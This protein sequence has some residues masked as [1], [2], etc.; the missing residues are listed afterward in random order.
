MLDS[1]FL[2]VEDGEE[3]GF[4][5]LANADDNAIGLGQ[6]RNRGKLLFARTI[7][8]D[9]L[10][11]HAGNVL[12]FFGMRIDDHDI[13]TERGQMTRKVVCRISKTDNNEL[14]RSHG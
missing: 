9:G 1:K 8:N 11:D 14:S 4:E 13:M 10:R 12:D 5:V 7:G 3:R 2:Q 6:G